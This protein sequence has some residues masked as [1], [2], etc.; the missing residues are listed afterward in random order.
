MS[1]DLSYLN[2][3]YARRKMIE[4]Y[5]NESDLQDNILI[6]Q[7]EKQIMDAVLSSVASAKDDMVK[8]TFFMKRT[9]LGSIDPFE[10]VNK[11]MDLRVKDETEAK[12]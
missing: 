12:Q 3:E 4:E 10:Y 11:T 1:E 6:K 5:N 8:L 9:D 2:S 7:K